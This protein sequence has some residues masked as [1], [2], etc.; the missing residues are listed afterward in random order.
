MTGNQGSISQEKKHDDNSLVQTGKYLTFALGKED[1]GLEILKVREIIGMM[2][3]T[4]VPQVPKYVKG[5]INLRGK[6]IP[7][8][9]LRLKFG[10]DEIE[11]T[12]ET[13]I[14]VVTINEILIGI[15]IDRVKEVLNINQENIEPPPNFGSTINTEFILGIGKV[16]D[17][18]KM[19]LN[20][21]KIVGEDLTLIENQGAD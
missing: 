18:V 7:V 1:Y 3:I 8:I 12:A 19:L 15:I 10:M 11:Y 6:V 20:I 9:D 16:S 5:V 2:E 17:S 13:C 14:I 4:K 21:D